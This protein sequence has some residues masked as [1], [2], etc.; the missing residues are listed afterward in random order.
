MRRV[1]EARADLAW[2][3]KPHPW[4]HS[5]LLIGEPGNSTANHSKLR[6]V[7]GAVPKAKETPTPPLEA[8]L[9]GAPLRGF[10]SVQG[11]PLEGRG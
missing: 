7:G 11:S 9:P 8:A 10:G 5:S 6:S 3:P 2:E 4:L 1:E